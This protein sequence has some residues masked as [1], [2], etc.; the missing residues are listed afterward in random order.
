M[1]AD[2][3]MTPP[4]YESSRH[5]NKLRLIKLIAALPLLIYPMVLI[6]GLMALAAPGAGI[7]GLDSF[8][9]VSFIW[10]SLTYPVTFF[11]SMLFNKRRSLV[12]ASLPLM[13]LALALLLFVFWWMLG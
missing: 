5:E 11:G 6:A 3:A 4:Y 1:S 8:I 2:T 7:R 12:I 10:V 9:A 13:H